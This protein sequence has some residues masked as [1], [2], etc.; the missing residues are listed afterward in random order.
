MGFSFA[1]TFKIWNRITAD[2][3]P[4]IDRPKMKSS[5][6]TWRISLGRKQEG[7]RHVIWQSVINVK[8]LCKIIRVCQINC[9]FFCV[10]LFFVTPTFLGFFLSVYLLFYLV[11]S[12]FFHSG[13]S[14][15]CRTSC[16]LFSTC[17]LYLADQTASSA[18]MALRNIYGEQQIK[19]ISTGRSLMRKKARKINTIE[20]VRLSGGN[21]LE[22]LESPSAV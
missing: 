7:I 19:K 21:S 4:V 2:F 22:A 20:A 1:E 12:A 10:F 3:F 9:V 16:R 11:V 8:R 17:L 5:V 6:R 15:L 14:I 13:I 18:L